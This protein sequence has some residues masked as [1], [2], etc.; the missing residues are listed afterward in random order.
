MWIKIR[1]INKRQN[2]QYSTKKAYRFYFN[3]T[4]H[5]WIASC[6]VWILYVLRKNVIPHHLYFFIGGLI[7]LDMVIISQYIKSVEYH[8]HW[9]HITPNKLKQ[10]QSIPNFLFRWRR[11]V[12]TTTYFSPS[13][14]CLTL[15]GLGTSAGEFFKGWV[16]DQ[17]KGMQ[18]H[19]LLLGKSF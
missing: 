18:K 8:Q 13:L 16:F 3:N 9:R 2:E 4:M 17:Q 7:N 19:Q 10:S 11:V 6:M 12:S 5:I 1:K 15:L 14:S